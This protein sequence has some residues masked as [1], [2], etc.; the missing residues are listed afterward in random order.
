MKSGNCNMSA[1]ALRRLERQK[2]EKELLSTPEPQDASDD[3]EEFEQPAK[4]KVNAFALL[5]DQDESENE[6]D[7]EISSKPE[8]KKDEIK[9]VILLTKSSKTEKESKEETNSEAS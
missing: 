3:K 4:P 1:R 5:N 7:E 6:S 9:P 8:I 2:L